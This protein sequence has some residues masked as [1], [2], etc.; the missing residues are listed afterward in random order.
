MLP[1][2]LVELGRPAVADREP[3]EIAVDEVHLPV[4]GVAQ[5]GG[6]FDERVEDRVQSIPARDGPQDVDERAL[7]VLQPLELS[8]ELGGAH[9]AGSSGAIVRPRCLSSS[10]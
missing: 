2:V 6:G 4:L 10:Q 5:P 3:E 1:L 8:R 7:L 9:A